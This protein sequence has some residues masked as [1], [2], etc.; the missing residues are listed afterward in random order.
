MDYLKA[1]TRDFTLPHPD[2]VDPYTSSMAADMEEAFKKEWKH[3]MGNDDPPVIDDQLRLILIAVAQGVI[4]HLKDNRDAI[5]IEVP[6]PDGTGNIVRD[7]KE[8]KTKGKL[9]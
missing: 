4:K 5:T 7:L 8:V 2:G 9:Y 3:I 1:G 6:D